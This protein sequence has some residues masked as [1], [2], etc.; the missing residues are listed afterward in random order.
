MLQNLH[1]KNLALIDEAEVEFG[2]GLNVLSGETGA[3][4]SI[5][6]GSMNLALGNKV[7]KEMLREND[8]TA[9]V[10]LVFSVDSPQTISQLRELDVEVE[11]GTVIL[12]RKISAGRAIAKVNG[13]AVSTA[14]MKEVAS[15][16]ID[17]H[18]QHEHQSLLNKRKHLDFVDRYAKNELSD[19]KEKLA[20]LYAKFKKLNEEYIN[21]NLDVQERNRELSLL[22]YEVK[23]IE[24]A[25]PVIGEDEEL[26]TSFRRISNG[27]KILESFTTAMGYTS[28]DMDGASDLI[29]RAV[30]ELSL[31]TRY[32]ENAAEFEERLSEIENLLS[33]FNHELGSYIS[34]LSFDDETFYQIQCR[35]DLINHLKSKYGDTMEAILAA[36]EKKQERLDILLH[37]ED[38]TKKLKQELNIVEMELSDLCGEVSEIRQKA[39]KQL[40]EDIIT[41]LKEL[42][43]LDVTFDIDFKRMENYSS[44]GYDDVEFLI[45]TNPG[46]PLKPLDKIA[47]GGEMSRLLLALKAVFIRLSN[48]DLLIL[49]EI[50]T[51][52]SGKVALKVG[53]KI[54][55][56]SSYMQVIV[57]SHLAPVAAWALNQ[58]LIYK[59]DDD[60]S[61]H[62]NVKL[63]N[64]EER[65]EQL[66]IIS[67]TSTDE[68]ALKAA[69]EL[70]DSCQG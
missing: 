40:T 39:S 24:D 32:D 3:G 25:N 22:Q 35:L 26:E 7:P 4:K 58:Y 51:G 31:V 13:E 62:T 12:S 8:D 57:I 64:Y 55:K 33:D 15:L 47:S 50:D 11:D 5:I 16:L 30:R 69:K 6:I 65:I 23:E 20:D 37:Y 61:T 34:G 60:T 63:L 17:I 44:G 1:V 70:L 18:G 2:E 36:K 68:N 56:I 19:K 41:S 46:E 45:S 49:D 38:Y 66:A 27:K 67:N 28:S 48:T 42:N 52:V 9:F 54:K 59:E 53:E 21:S 29:G 14:R 43:F 10:E